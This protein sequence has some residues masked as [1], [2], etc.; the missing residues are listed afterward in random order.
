MVFSVKL[1]E[2][3]W[4]AIE[5][6]AVGFHALGRGLSNSIGAASVMVRNGGD[7]PAS[8]GLG[9]FTLSV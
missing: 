7:L 6:I 1:G 8:R 3:H 9:S 2:E 5:N 4:S